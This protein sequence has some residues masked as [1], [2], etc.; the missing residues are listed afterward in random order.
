VTDVGPIAPPDT[1]SPPTVVASPVGEKDPTSGPA[2][3]EDD[4]DAVA[5]GG[6]PIIEEPAT[7]VTVQ[8]L[9]RPKASTAE[10]SS[11]G[12]AG[13]ARAGGPVEERG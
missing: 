12:A 11:G 3:A 8:D 1:G 4:H 2:A 13:E 6:P 9:L 5:G 7:L 10:G